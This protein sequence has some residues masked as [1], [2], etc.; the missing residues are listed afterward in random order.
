M[1]VVPFRDDARYTSLSYNLRNTLKKIRKYIHDVGDYQSGV[2]FKWQKKEDSA[3]ETQIQGCANQESGTHTSRYGTIYEF[4]NRRGR[5]PERVHPFHLGATAIE[6][7][8]IIKLGPMVTMQGNVT[9]RQQNFTLIMVNLTG[10]MPTHIIEVTPHTPVEKQGGTTEGGVV[11]QS[12]I[13][14]PSPASPISI[15]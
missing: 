1:K 5:S 4:V 3:M 6:H 12:H 14:T 8:G 10:V 7:L 2:V 13:V 9:S 11:I 15:W